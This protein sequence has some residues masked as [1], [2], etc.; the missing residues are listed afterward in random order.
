MA[1]DGAAG[2]FQLVAAAEE[3]ACAAAAAT[4][5][6]LVVAKVRCILGGFGY[7][8]ISMPSVYS[9]L[10]V[11]RLAGSMSRRVTLFQTRDPY[12]DV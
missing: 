3:T 12:S 8:D 4:R 6:W 11:S 9:S 2:R 1:Y 7:L 10:C 5:T